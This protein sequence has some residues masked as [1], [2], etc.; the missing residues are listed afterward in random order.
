MANNGL[1]ERV[2]GSVSN[3]DQMLRHP[4]VPA[5]AKELLIDL[6]SLLLDVDHARRHYRRAVKLAAEEF[7]RLAP[8]KD[9]IGVE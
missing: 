3:I 2:S 7:A 6:R 4:A 9:A 5:E 8:G 1:T